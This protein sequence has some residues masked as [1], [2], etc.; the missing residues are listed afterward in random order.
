MT[1]SEGGA[2][3]FDQ[4][5]ARLR[6]ADPEVLLE[7]SGIIER[8]SKEACNDSNGARIIFRGAMDE[9]ERRFTLDIDASDSDAVLCLL[10]AIQGCLDLMP[11]ITKEYYATL[12]EALA[13]EAEEKGGLHDP[14]HV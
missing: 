6:G 1:F 4:I 13:L 7:W 11:A 5:R 14:W 9:E 10:N 2:F 8:R 12:M 3:W